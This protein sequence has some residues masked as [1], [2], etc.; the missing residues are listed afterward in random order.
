MNFT[1]HSQAGQDKFAYIVTGSRHGSFLDIGANN[2]VSINNTFG[3]EQLGWRGLLVDNS[4]ESMEACEKRRESHFYLTDASQPQNWQAALAQAELPTDIIDY[5][6]LDVDEAS[7]QCLKNLPLDKL[8]FRVMTVE[9]DEYRFPGRR[10]EMVAILESHGYDVL[11]KDVCD[12][13]L[14][15]EIWCVMP[16]LVDLD[17]A[18]KFRAT[19]STEWREFFKT[20]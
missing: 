20:T 16:G 11:C 6:S 18:D 9:T 14:S 3:L 4:A 1:S 13:G 5:C 10:D 15:F 2:P 17:R 8:R 12:K 7:L 19:K